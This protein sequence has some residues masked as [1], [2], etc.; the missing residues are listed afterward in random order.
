VLFV[1]STTVVGRTSGASV[2][3]F[4]GTETF[5]PF[6]LLGAPVGQF[7]DPGTVRC[8]GAEPTGDPIQPC[9][10]G[11]RTHSRDSVWVSRMDSSYP[12]G[13]GLATIHG[14]ANLDASFTGPQGGSFSLALDAG[15]TWEG[16]FEG[17][18]VAEGDHWITELHGTAR[19]HGGEIDGLK[20]MVDDR[21]VGFT[22]IPIVYVGTILGRV[23]DPRSN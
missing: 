17:V 12:G 22:P 23:L 3:E 1:A 11:S 4:T 15:G 16:T 20:L 10:V 2:V 13:S 5:D 19:G 14:N 6:G 18:R 21:I 8:P 7:L 9:P